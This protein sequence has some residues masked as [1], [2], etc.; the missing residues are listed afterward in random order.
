[1][2]LIAPEPVNAR[3]RNRT[4]QKGL[5]IVNAGRPAIFMQPQESFLNEV[6]GYH[7]GYGPGVAEVRANAVRA[8]DT[9]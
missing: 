1:M 2:H 4:D 5:A 9:G 3:L 6:V 7:P 8:G